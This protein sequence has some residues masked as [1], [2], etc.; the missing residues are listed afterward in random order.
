MIQRAYKT[1]RKLNNGEIVEFEGVF[2]EKENGELQPGD[3]YIAERNTGPQLLTVEK[4]VYEN[5]WLQALEGELDSTHIYFLHK[6][7][8]A[9]D[10]PKYGLFHHD[11][12][13]RFQIVNTE[14][15]MT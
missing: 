12:S 5:N 2:F 9:E 3:T 8:N 14:F 7:L 4:I 15:G 11:Q 1:I 6:R 10:S 13:A